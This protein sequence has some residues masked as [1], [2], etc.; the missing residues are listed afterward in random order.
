MAAW[1]E[2]VPLAG[3]KMEIAR[4]EM[5]PEAVLDETLSCYEDEFDVMVM[6]TAPGWDTLAGKRPVL[7]LGRLYPRF[8][9][10]RWPLRACDALR[11]G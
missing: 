5:A 10:S 8:P 6:D 1:P 7:L 4:R 9:W 3:V 11:S 2:G